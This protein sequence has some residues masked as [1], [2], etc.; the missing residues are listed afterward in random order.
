MSARSRKQLTKTAGEVRGIRNRRGIV[1]ADGR[2]S[3]DLL[4]TRPLERGNS[5]I[6]TTHKRPPSGTTMP[7]KSSGKPLFSS[8]ASHPWER[9]KRPVGRGNEMPSPR[10]FTSIAVRRRVLNSFSITDNPSLSHSDCSV[11]GAT[12]QIN[13]RIATLSPDGAPSACS[14]WTF[15]CIWCAPGPG[16]GCGVAR[17]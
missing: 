17:D 15:E 6:S 16:P 1:I 2:C 7:V 9:T 3:F 5:P 10:T 4:D 11:T 14:E 8:M 12:F 13:A